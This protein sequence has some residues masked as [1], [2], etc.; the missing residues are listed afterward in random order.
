M[1]VQ[2]AGISVVFRSKNI[3]YRKSINTDFRTFYFSLFF[4]EC[5]LDG[6]PWRDFS[7]IRKSKEIDSLIKRKS[8]YLFSCE[9]CFSHYISLLVLIF[10]QFKLVFDDG[11]GFGVS[12]FDLVFIANVYM[13]IYGL[14]RQNLKAEKI[15]AE[16][17]YTELLELKEKGE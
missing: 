10:S 13:T 17:K 14:L 9:Y 6:Y 1:S 12:F 2:F 15:E 7:G 4:R 11:R 16:L 5:R 8:F 3:I